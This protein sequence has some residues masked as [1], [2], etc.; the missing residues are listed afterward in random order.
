MLEGRGCLIDGAGEFPGRE[1]EREVQRDVQMSPD[2]RREVE[3]EVAREVETSTIPAPSDSGADVE[4]PAGLVSGAAD[5]GGC[6]GDPE[7]PL[8]VC[9]PSG[10]A[11][12]S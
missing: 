8:A 11:C 5:H 7:E 6:L 10:C 12:P 1:V 9:S 4:H 2:P 3:R